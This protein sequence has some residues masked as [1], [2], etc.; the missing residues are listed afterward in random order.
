M[1]N[2]KMLA[3]SWKEQ[4]PEWVNYEGLVTQI[5]PF[6]GALFLL[7][8]RLPLKVATDFFFFFANS[9]IMSI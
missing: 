9:R 6:E 2:F 1:S 8:K 4:G 3:F 5:F 7:I